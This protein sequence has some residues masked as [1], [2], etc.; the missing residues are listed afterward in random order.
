LYVNCIY[1]YIMSPFFY[2]SI[3]TRRLGFVIAVAVVL[4]RLL[5]REPYTN[6]M[7]LIF[8][9]YDVCVCMYVI[10]YVVQAGKL[11]RKCAQLL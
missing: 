7:L 11:R 5:I 2:I 10:M 4:N 1:C 6:C 8:H 9:V 3:R